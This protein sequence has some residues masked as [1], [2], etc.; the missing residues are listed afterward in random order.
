MDD[1]G[2]VK[3]STTVRSLLKLQS[4][5]THSTSWRAQAMI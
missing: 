2:E 5:L 4:C 3:Q 1:T